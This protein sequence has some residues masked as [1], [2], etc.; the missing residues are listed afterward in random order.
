MDRV[1]AAIHAIG[2]GDVVIVT[3]DPDREGEGDL[4]MAAQSATQEKIAFV[5]Q[6]TSGLICAPL[7]AQRAAEL[8]LP[9]M[10][11]DNQDARQTAYTVSVDA[12]VGTTTG[13]SAAD[14]ALTLRTVAS[15]TAC[16]TDLVRPGHVFPLRAR[17]GGVLERPGHT[18]AAVDLTRMAEIEPVG[19]ICEV[20]TPDRAG[21]AGRRELERLARTHTL[22]MVSIAELVGHRLRSE[23][24]VEHVAEARVPTAAGAFTCHAWRSLTDGAEHLA[25]VCGDL[26]GEEPVLV[27]VHS[28]CLTGDVFGSSRCD[29]GSQLHAAMRLIS[30]AGRGVI[31]YLRGHEGRGVGLTHKLRAYNLQDD[32]RDTVDANLELGLPVDDRDYGIG[33][34]ILHDL[35]VTRMRLITNNPAK[36]YGLRGFGLEVVDRVAVPPH[37]TPENLGY[38]RAKRDRMS[39]LLPGLEAGAGR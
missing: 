15:P 34:Q 1:E 33:A 26:R 17:A 24:L 32:G 9:P 22:P 19:M 12:A 6:H 5:L 13:I 18:E 30:A 28:E 2:S 14:R 10:V 36:Y 25:F 16:P 35:G 31:V 27:R 4:V 38:L 20:V 39:H 23:R 37:A 21:M 3:D 29:C 7:T 8:E 11:E